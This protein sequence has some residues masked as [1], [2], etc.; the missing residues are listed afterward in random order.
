MRIETTKFSCFFS[1]NET[2]CDIELEK[3]IAKRAVEDAKQSKLPSCY[4]LNL[5]TDAINSAP[6][7]ISEFLLNNITKPSGK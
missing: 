6:T 3:E 5:I 1:M 2:A 7:G 4:H